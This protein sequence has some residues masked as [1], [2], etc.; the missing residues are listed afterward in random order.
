MTD[1]PVDPLHDAALEFERAGVD[2][3]V[4]RRVLAAVR[5]RWSGET[6]IRAKDP[7]ID[8]EIERRLSA[9]E[10]PRE[11]AEAT[12]RHRSTVIRRRTSRWL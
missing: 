6:Y 2:V 3:V 12:G 9:G 5:R 1:A 4:V 10:H 8:E 11:I 7:L